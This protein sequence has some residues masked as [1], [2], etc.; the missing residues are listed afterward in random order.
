MAEMDNR[1]FLPI[2]GVNPS[3]FIDLN[4][5]NK[6][7]MKGALLSMPIK[8]IDDTGSK[9]DIFDTADFTK[10]QNARNINS[11]QLA[12]PIS[13]RTVF[14]TDAASFASA[15]KLLE[16]IREAELEKQ[17]HDKLMAAKTINLASAGGPN[18][19]ESQYN[20]AMESLINFAANLSNILGNKDFS[21]NLTKQEVT[22]EENYYSIFDA[23]NLDVKGLSEEQR[24]A[25]VDAVRAN[26]SFMS[27]SELREFA[28]RFPGLDTVLR[29]REALIKKSG[30]GLIDAEMKS[31]YEISQILSSRSK[32]SLINNL[33]ERS[34]TVNFRASPFDSRTSN[35]RDELN[36]YPTIDLA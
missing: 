19:V 15:Q 28:S 24:N 3:S 26:T 12:D 31:G 13:G 23:I 11:G 34:D 8:L 29:N 27:L 7:Y 21:I 14:F 16:E 4:K 20:T 35:N 2:G 22:A 25:V 10:L 36:W 9:T 1:D 33:I 5:E 18:Q 32:E 17:L 30:L 6:A